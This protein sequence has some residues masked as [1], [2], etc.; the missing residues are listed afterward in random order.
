MYSALGQLFVLLGL[1]AAMAGA[2]CALAGAAWGGVYTH[3]TLRRCA[4]GFASC[5]ALANATMVVALL[6][7]DFSVSYV[8]QVGSR[9]T[10][11][12][13]TLVSL[14]SSLAGSI[15]F[16]GIIL[17]VYVV[18]FAIDTRRRDEPWVGWAFAVLFLIAAFFALLIAGPA[19]PFTRV[20]SPPAD[21]PGPNP[22]LQNHWLMAIHPPMLYLGYVGMVVPFAIGISALAVGKLSPSVWAAMRRFMLWPWTFLSVGIVLGSWWAYEVLGWGGFWAWDPVENAS[23]LPWLTAT[24]YLHAA[25]MQERRRLLKSWSV[26]L[27]LM[28]FLLTILG[29]FMT[30]SGVFNSVHS[31]TQS[32]IG[33]VFLWFLAAMLVLS[34]GLLGGRGHLLADE[35]ALRAVWSRETA[36][37]LNNVALVVFTFTVLLGTVFPLL[38]EAVTGTK[39]SVGEP[40]FDR[41]AAPLGLLLLFL[42]GV[43]PTLPWGQPDP[44]RVRRDFLWPLGAGIVGAAVSFA[45]GRGGLLTTLSF[46][47]CA[48]AGFVNLR[49]LVGPGWALHRRQKVS[50]WVGI[51]RS[52]QRQQ[53]RTGGALV[54]LAIVLVG[55]GITGAQSFRITQEA[56]LGRGD[57]MQLGEFTVTYQGAVGRQEPHRFAAVARLV[58]KRGD[59][60]LGVMEPRLHFYPTQREPVGTPHVVTLGPKDLYLSLLSLENGGQQVVVKGF[61]IPLVALLWRSLPFIV[62][63]ALVSL[64]P[65]AR[66]GRAA[67]A[68]AAAPASL[69]VGE[70]GAP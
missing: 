25:A 41:M 37:L 47:L 27:V 52:W 66:R 33:P 17:G 2:T 68:T 39:L 20:L 22:L 69:A 60:V 30:R 51:G 29:T 21:G 12:L 9:A 7:H 28:T 24:G 46:G 53:R 50:L 56:A 3:R 19:N 44:S 31:F 57:S 14:W 55:A 40:Y 67:L 36:F 23:F 61:V 16:W 1:I 15:L 8:A 65:Q 6:R 70:G 48:F 64:W 11:W 18:A 54:H 63:G 43:G 59:E 26:A 35:G 4:F 13:L 10:P 38:T 34:A 45:V 62:A 32:P 49:E 5:M 42:M 58:V